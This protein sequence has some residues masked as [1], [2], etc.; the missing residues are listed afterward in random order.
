MPTVSVKL[1]EE[2]KQR[3]Q[4]V[5]QSQGI[6]AHAVMVDAIEAALSRVEYHNALAAIALRARAQV[7]ES[8]KVFDGPAFSAY[9]KAKVLG[10]KPA[11]PRPVSLKSVVSGR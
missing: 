3:I 11:R 6:T 5:A 10:K 8:G 2:T 7:V 4:S 1:P 9:L